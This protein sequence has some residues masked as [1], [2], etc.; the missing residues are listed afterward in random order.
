MIL[1]IFTIVSMTPPV[2]GQNWENLNAAAA[3]LMDQGHPAAARQLYQAGLDLVPMEDSLHRSVLLHNL[4]TAAYALGDYSAALKYLDSAGEGGGAVVLNTRASLL[5][6]IGRTEEAGA[7]F[8]RAYKMARGTKDE[9]PIL[10]NLAS[11]WLEKDSPIIASNYAFNALYKTSEPLDSLMA[12]RVLERAS[13]LKEEH[14]DAGFFRNSAYVILS[15]RFPEDSYQ[16]LLQMTNE[17]YTAELAGDYTRASSL[18]STALPGW[19]TLLGKDNPETITVAYGIA[20]SALK[21]GDQERALK[22]YL[23]YLPAKLSFLGSEALRLGQ[24][25]LRSFWKINSEGIL[26]APLY[27]TIAARKHPEELGTL[28][29]AVMLSKSFN[30]ETVRSFRQQVEMAH[31]AT[32]DSLYVAFLESRADLTSF[33]REKSETLEKKLTGMLAARGLSSNK[34]LIPSWKESRDKMPVRSVAVEFA[35]GG[36]FIYG[37]KDKTPV[38]VSLPSLDVV[39]PGSA[40][41]A[42]DLIHL[43]SKIWGPLEPFIKDADNVFF[44]PFGD[45]HLLPLEV[46][47][48]SSGIPFRNKHKMVVRLVSTADIPSVNL[49]PKISEYILFG[50]MDYGTPGDERAYGFLTNIPRLT[51]S[52]KEMDEL[53]LV[54]QNRPHRIF[55]KGYASEEAFRGIR[56]NQDAP[57]LLHMSTHGLFLSYIEALSMMFYEDNYSAEILRENPMLRNVMLMSGAYDQWS[58]KHHEPL[59]DATITAQEISE[60]DLR[61]VSFAVLAACQTAI[62]DGSPEGVLGFPYAFKLAG[63]GGTLAALWAVN[64][65]VT[66]QIMNMF[67]RGLIEGASPEEALKKASEHIRTEKKYSDPFYW[68]PFVIVR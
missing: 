26:D 25:D 47:T 27:A 62:G 43:Y 61:G 1:V 53:S 20:K 14:R 45:A 3:R 58:A 63:A 34:Q 48:D 29:N 52:E 50:D 41:M 49:H 22:A 17:A 9:V 65:D 40:P 23:D 46:L 32:L 11:L 54:L 10:L 68:A 39:K 33:D 38:Y 5:R 60:M 56:F 36:A 24:D 13:V 57:V 18:Y 66:C 37:K 31:D 19:T 8:E 7:L 16:N 2:F 12:F 35:D 59:H 28:L 30:R 44:S 67:Y 51:G 6:T 21:A 15:R 42:E 55:R 64:D 4:A